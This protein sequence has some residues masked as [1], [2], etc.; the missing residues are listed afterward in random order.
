MD[1]NEIELLHSITAM[2][3]HMESSF[4]EMRLGNYKLRNEAVKPDHKQTNQRKDQSEQ[5]NNSTDVWP[6]INHPWDITWPVGLPPA[7]PVSKPPSTCPIKNYKQQSLTANSGE[8]IL[9]ELFRLCQ[10]F[11]GHGISL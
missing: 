1:G 7:K 6:A 2:T 8:D 5:Q 11:C 3:E 10:L 9:R 4:Q